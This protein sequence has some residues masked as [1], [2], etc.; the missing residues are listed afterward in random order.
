MALR[1]RR[2]ATK[3]DTIRCADDDT[4]RPSQ[5]SSKDRSGHARSPAGQLGFCCGLGS[6]ECCVGKWSREQKR[7]RGK[8]SWR[9]EEE[10]CCEPEGRNRFDVLSYPPLVRVRGLQVSAIGSRC[11]LAPPCPP[12]VDRQNKASPNRSA[13][14]S[15]ALCLR[16]TKAEKAG[17]TASSSNPPM[18]SFSSVIQVNSI[19][20]ASPPVPPPLQQ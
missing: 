11:P 15:S 1:K 9:G 20:T 13:L 19:S 10:G 2:R 7:S 14:L 6:G 3:W 4:F 17:R 12:L 5:L 8:I 18:S 16:S